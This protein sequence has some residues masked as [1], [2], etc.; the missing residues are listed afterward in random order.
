MLAPKGMHVVAQGYHPTA[1][2]RS[3][4]LI[5]KRRYAFMNRYLGSKDIYGPCMMR[6][7]ASTQISIDYTSEAGLPPKNEDCLCAYPYLKPDLRQ[8]ADIRRQAAPT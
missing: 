7:S 5:P 1:T 4:D 2:A 6:G 8:F 3:L